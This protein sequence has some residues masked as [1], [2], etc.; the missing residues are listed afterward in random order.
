M[1][2][3]SQLKTTAERK[4]RRRLHLREVDA[5]T[6]NTADAQQSEN[7]DEA[8]E[9]IGHTLRDARVARGEDAATVAAKLKMRR[10]QLEAIEAGDYAKLPGRTYALGFLRS[11]ARYLELDD[12]AIVQRFKAES[13][14]EPGA[15]AVDLVFPE[16]TDDRRMMPNPS[17]LGWAMLVALVIYGISYLTMPGRK[18]PTTAKADQTGVIIEEPK[19]AQ[20]AQSTADTWSAPAP[21]ASTTATASDQ[22]P[23]E[24]TTF[25]AGA[26]ALSEAEVT[27]PPR[28]WGGDPVHA[29]DMNAALTQLADLSSVAVAL[30]QTASGDPSRITFKAIE[31]TYVRIKDPKLTG[32][33]AILLERVMQP[34][35]SY[36]VPGRTGLTMKTGNAGGVQVEVDGR[37]VGVLGKSGEVITRLPVD[38][39]YF[40]ERLAVSQ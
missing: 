22:P 28:L 20:P 15:K 36:Q 18:G 19:P 37:T 24:N 40:L 3:V 31:E 4:E 38:A 29:S 25:V 16:A 30:P 27:E 7:Q 23:G 21:A 14:G 17:L 11:Y 1:S 9:P 26:Q 12:E 10:D 39:S 13:G 33:E 32:R 8:E 6:E 35:E 34:G 5:E 2:N